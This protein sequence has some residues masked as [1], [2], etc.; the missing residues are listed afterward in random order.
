MFQNKMLI[1]GR[2]CN[3]ASNNTFAVINPR[4]ETVLSRVPA[5]G[6]ADVDTAVS[7]AAQA[8]PAWAALTPFQRGRFLRSASQM[9]LNRKDEIGRLMAREQGKPVQEATGEVVKGADI[10]RFYAEEG[11][12]VHGKIIAGEEAGTTSRIIYQPLGVA[13]AISPWNYPVELLAWKVGAALAAGCTLVAKLPSETPLSPLA[14]L[15]C[16][17]DAGIPAGVINALTGS[18]SGIGPVL[19]GDPR[20]KK[21]A[22]TGSTEVGKS[23]LGYC[24]PNLTRSS[25]ELGGSLPLLVFADCDLEAAVKGA[26]RRSFRNMGQICIAVNRI[27]VQR[28]IYDNFLNRMTG[29]TKHLIIGDGLDEPADLGP[30]CTS[31]GRQ[32]VISHIEDALARGASIRC[33]GQIPAGYD[34]G[35]WFEPT[36]IADASQDMLIMRE[37]TFGPAVGVMPF[38]TVDQA[39]ALANDTPY[40]LAAIVYTQ[41]LSIAERCALEIAAGNVAINNPDPGVINAPYGGIRDSGFGKEHGAEGLYEYLYAKHIRI[42]V[43]P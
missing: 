33:G 32:K 29:Q 16:L 7:A 39:I 18:G 23:V 1:N 9:V 34:K 24:T 14:F 41:N 38:D 31:A 4:D 6:T 20:V 21:V 35:Y 37:E 12:R 8:F 3:A 26:V 2:W 22:F 42:R 15:A 11:E 25:L 17:A 40:G 19:V 27:Y 5:A 36:I 28:E 43:L 30:M 13:A 10:L